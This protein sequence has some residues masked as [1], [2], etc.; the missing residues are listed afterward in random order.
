MTHTTL[1]T[2]VWPVAAD[3]NLV[4]N[5]LLMIAGVVLVAGAAHISISMLPVPMT[6]QT[7]AVLVVGATYGS[8]FGALTMLAYAA[9]GAVGL[10]V[11]SPTADGY[12]GIMGPTGGYIIGFILAA[13][14][15]GWFAERGY[16]RSPLSMLLPMVLGAAIVYVPGL[17]WLNGFV[18]D[19]GKTFELGLTPFVWGDSIKTIVATLGIPALWSLFERNR[20]V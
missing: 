20:G 9:A 1:S 18:G 12:P 2:K 6:L 5:L 16:D 8:R 15:V 19:F 13:G 17:M 3:A 7:L 11:F 4:R 14:V 10:P